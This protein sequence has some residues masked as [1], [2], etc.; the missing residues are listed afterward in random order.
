MVLGRDRR[1]AVTNR[2]AMQHQLLRLARALVVARLLHEGQ[3]PVDDHFELFVELRAYIGQD[4]R[5]EHLHRL[6]S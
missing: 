5:L 2:L 1:R 4:W 3:P 6:G